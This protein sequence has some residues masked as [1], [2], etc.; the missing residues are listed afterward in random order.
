MRPRLLGMRFA[1]RAPGTPAG[2]H[3]GNV[4]STNGREGVGPVRRVCVGGRAYRRQDDSPMNDRDLGANARDT[5]TYSR[6]VAVLFGLTTEHIR[7]P[8]PRTSS[9][10]NKTNLLSCRVPPR[11]C[12]VSFT[13][14]SGI[15]HSID[16]TAESLFEAAALGLSM[17]RK[18]GWSEPIAPGTQ[19]EVK[20]R[21]P[22]TTHTLSV[23]QIQRWCDGVA[24]SP[25]EVLKRQRVKRLLR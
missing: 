9:R 16:V 15:R 11:S 4:T 14:P 23:L 8:T 17:L 7:G 13:G 25:D 22:A 1:D 20:V 5:R 19:L 21:E 3:I 12:T 10:R 18:R 24:I 6:E 2:L